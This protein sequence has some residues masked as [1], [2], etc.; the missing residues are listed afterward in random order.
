MPVSEPFID[1]FEKLPPILNSHST[2]Q[3]TEGLWFLDVDMIGI[4]GGFGGGFDWSEEFDSDDGAYIVD[5]DNPTVNATTSDKRIR[6]NNPG[7]LVQSKDGQNVTH[8]SITRRATWDNETLLYDLLMPRIQDFSIPRDNMI[9]MEAACA[10]AAVGL[11]FTHDVQ[12]LVSKF[13]RE[14]IKWHLQPRI[15]FEGHP[16]L[17]EAIL[18]EVISIAICHYLDDDYPRPDNFEGFEEPIVEEITR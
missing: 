4:S 12:Y 3:K 9:S 16:S 7:F 11:Q 6:L 8:L 17:V 10:Y 2:G 18:Y 15:I 14:N 13:E 5:T 1:E